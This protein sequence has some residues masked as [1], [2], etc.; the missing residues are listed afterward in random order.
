ML[1]LY[2]KKN[3]CKQPCLISALCEFLQHFKRHEKGFSI[4]RDVKSYSPILTPKVKK[5]KNQ[6]NDN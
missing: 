6:V 3:K 4:I 1:E 2:K 5:P